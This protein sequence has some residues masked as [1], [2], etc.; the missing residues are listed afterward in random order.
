MQ[1]HAKITLNPDENRSIQEKLGVTAFTKSTSNVRIASSLSLDKKDT[2]AVN[3]Q[4]NN[5]SEKSV[6]QQLKGRNEP[7]YLQVLTGTIRPINAAAN[8]AFNDH[9][10]LRAGAEV[11]TIPLDD[12]VSVV[13][14]ATASVTHELRLATETDD[15]VVFSQEPT[16]T[17]MVTSNVSTSNDTDQKQTQTKIKSDI[18]DLPGSNILILKKSCD[19]YFSR[20]L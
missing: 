18:F 4:L 6:T 17:D 3:A 5:L 1:I 8:N 10:P 9:V 7:H 19:R 12:D 11:T 20:R 15:K 2:Q 13:N 14:A 16:D